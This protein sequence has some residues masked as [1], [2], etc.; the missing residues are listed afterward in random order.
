M[1]VSCFKAASFLSFA[2]RRRAIELCSSSSPELT[3]SDRT[4]EV[5]RRS[6]D[7]RIGSYVLMGS[8]PDLV[9]RSPS[10]EDSGTTGF[11]V[12]AMLTG[13][14]GP[15]LSLEE[16][17]PGSTAGLDVTF[18]GDEERRPRAFRGDEMTGF[19]EIELP[20]KSA[21]DG[22]EEVGLASLV[23]DENCV[24]R[25]SCDVGRS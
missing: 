16:V 2:L 23:G 17:V 10:W 9:L 22:R 11:S 4:S 18:T 1:A 3:G 15:P 8:G 14:L 5:E 7:L 12:D 20:G 25:N 24:P 19:G 21:G 6:C 13:L